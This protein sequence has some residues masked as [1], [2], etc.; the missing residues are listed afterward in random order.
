MGNKSIPENIKASRFYLNEI[1]ANK[2]KKDPDKKKYNIVQ[3]VNYE[4]LKNEKDNLT[5]KVTTE[6]FVDPN[7]LFH[8]KLEHIADFMLKKEMSDKDVEENIKELLSPLGAEVSYI[9]ASITRKMIGVHL[10]LPPHLKI[11]K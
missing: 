1:V 7:E 10:I 11:E 8:I 3:E 6:T 2:I 4:I 9:V 5:I